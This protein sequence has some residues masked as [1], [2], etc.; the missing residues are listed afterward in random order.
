MMPVRETTL[1]TGDSTSIGVTWEA[2]RS[3]HGSRHSRRPPS[4][5]RVPGLG[6]RTPLVGF[7]HNGVTLVELLV[8]LGIIA[9]VVGISVPS[10][11]G[12]A[13]HLRLK[14]A[15]RQVVGLLSFARS[16]AISSHADYAV[17]FD[18]DRQELVVTNVISGETLERVVKLPTS[19]TL[20]FQVGGE[21][22]AETQVTFHSTG[23]LAGRTTSL[24]LSDQ[25]HHH[26]I[27]VTGAT[28][29]VTVQD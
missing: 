23:S 11:S 20:E 18:A 19:V 13:K 26:T 22:S 6:R 14:T 16:S 29:A 25:E 1:L 17:I 24:V 15:I 7:G 8:V 12:Y 9:L 4:F 5:R 28:G 27:T 2:G 3:P 10:L 21:A